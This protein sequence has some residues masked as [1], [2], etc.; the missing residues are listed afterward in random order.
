MKKYRKSQLIE[1]V[2]EYWNGD[3]LVQN[4]GNPDDQWVIPK[5][6]FE[7]TYEEVIE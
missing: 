2:A 3:R 5:E 4:E 6:V 7:T 1:V